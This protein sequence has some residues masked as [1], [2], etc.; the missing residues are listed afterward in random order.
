[1]GLR[2]LRACILLPLRPRYGEGDLTDGRLSRGYRELRVGDRERLPEK[3]RP[4][5]RSRAAERERDVRLRKLLEWE[6]EGGGERE[7]DLSEGRRLLKLRVGEMARRGRD[8]DLGDGR[9]LLRA[10]EREG[11]RNARR[12]RVADSGRIRLRE[13]DRREPLWSGGL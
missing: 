7:V 11:D 6:A 5:D 8:R 1:M 3:V 4:R 12:L 9:W 13:R 10:E 2:D